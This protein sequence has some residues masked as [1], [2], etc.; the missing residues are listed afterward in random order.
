[1][2]SPFLLKKGCCLCGNA[3]IHHNN[4]F[5]SGISHFL[6]VLCDH[7]LQAAT[8]GGVALEDVGVLQKAFGV[9]HHGQHDEPCIGA[10]SLLRPNLAMR[11]ICFRPSNIEYQ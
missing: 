3:R 8:I 4:S 1:M 11:L 5:F 6:V 10:F 7:A 9:D 2:G